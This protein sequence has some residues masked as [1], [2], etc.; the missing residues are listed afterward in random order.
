MFGLMGRLSPVHC[1][2]W[3]GSYWQM[4]VKWRRG[5]S[6][7]CGD[8]I[9]SVQKAGRETPKGGSKEKLEY[10]PS[11]QWTSQG[12]RWTK[13]R[14][15]GCKVFYCWPPKG[16]TRSANSERGRVTWRCKGVQQ[17][18]PN[19]SCTS[20]EHI[21]ELREDD[22]SHQKWNQKPENTQ[23]KLRQLTEDQISCWTF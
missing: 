7:R 17:R 21:Y 4:I 11:L 2:F 6:G 19:V 1:W 9:T 5:T 12:Q 23:I 18:Q 14:V 10:S 3:R 15:G 16:E 8:V 22:D 20:A 13:V